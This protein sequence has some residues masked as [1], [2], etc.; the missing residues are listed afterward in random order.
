MADSLK[1]A[2]LEY[3][4]NPPTLVKDKDGQAGNQKTKYADLEQVNEKVLKRLNEL[5]VVYTST[6]TIVDGKFALHCELEHVASETKLG[7]PWPIVMNENSQRMGSA[8]SYARRYALLALTNTAAA[9][10]DDDGHGGGRRTVQRQARPAAERTVQRPGSGTA[11]ITPPQMRKLQAL[12]TE[13]GI[14]DREQR[15][16]VVGQIVDRDVASA[17]DLTL[18]EATKVIDRLLSTPAAP[19]EGDQP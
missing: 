12:F 5:G 11:G 3:Q 13:A 19:A 7:G 16:A 17:N 14:S 18:E 9:S 10:E 15:L 6:P 4:A 8:V 2:L 1:Q